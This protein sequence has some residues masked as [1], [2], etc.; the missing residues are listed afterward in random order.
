MTIKNFGSRVASIWEGLRPETRKM[1][2]GAL[3]S[4]DK[5]FTFPTRKFYY[6]AHSDLELSRLLSAL[7]EQSAA[8]NTLLESTKKREIEQLAD[9][10]AALLE[11]QTGSAEVFIQLA[12]R[13]LERNDFKG[14]DSLS[15]KLAE[16][17]LP[18]EIAE[19]IRQ[20]DSAPIR[21]IAFETLALMPI[22]RLASILEDSAYYEIAVNALE[23]QAFEFGSEEA[24]EILMEAGILDDSRID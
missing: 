7:D 17:F 14:L 21:A 6:D 18:I 4:K 16:R 12:E 23:Q 15:D 22:S 10:C 1:L 13:Y 24:R 3:G 20:T 19:I 9:A 5:P 11:A 2:V 8:T